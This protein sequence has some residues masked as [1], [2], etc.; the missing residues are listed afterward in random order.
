MSVQEDEPSDS[1]SEE[2]ES[3]DEPSEKYDYEA[4]I[5]PLDILQNYI[6]DESK[7]KVSYDHL[8]DEDKIL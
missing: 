7:E 1:M 2:E 4:R 8:K 5:Y 3:D 6:P